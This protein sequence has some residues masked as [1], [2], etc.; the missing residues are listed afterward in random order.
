MQLE[1]WLDAARD[2]E[3][4]VAND[5]DAT[6]IDWMK[7]VAVFATAAQQGEIAEYR[8]I[9][10]LMVD[11]FRNSEEPGDIERTLKCCLLLPGTPVVGQL[12]V[13]LITAAQE[14]GEIT[15]GLAPWFDAAMAFEAYRRGDH[16]TAIELAG[17]GYDKAE[18]QDN[19]NTLTMRALAKSVSSLAHS[20]RSEREQ[21]TRDLAVARELVADLLKY[22]SDGTLTGNSVLNGQGNVNHDLLI[23]HIL[24]QE[25]TAALQTK[26]VDAQ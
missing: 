16:S 26:T 23:A 22:H 18:E 25:A 21:A 15:D 4:S 3:V 13:E 9:C 12:P 1:R 2:L 17:K 19:E 10:G 24:I 6:S 14:N 20:A 8:R 11:R 7:L 5:P